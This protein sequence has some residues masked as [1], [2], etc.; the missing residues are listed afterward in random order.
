VARPLRRLLEEA[1]CPICLEYFSDPVSMDYGHNFC[2]GCITEYH[3]KLEIE[4]AGVF[5]PQCRSKVK[6]EKS[7]A[8]RQL[9]RMVENIQQLGIK[10]EDLKKQT[11]CREHEDKLKLFCEDDGEVICLLCDKTQEHGSHTLVPIEDAAQE[12][13]ERVKCQRQRISSEFEKLQLLLNEKK[14][15]FIQ[16]L[17]EEERETLK[18]LNENVTKLSQQSS[19]LQQLITEIEEKCQQP[20]AELLQGKLSQSLRK[21]SSSWGEPVTITNK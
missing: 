2:R 7:Q 18:K 15:H 3:E 10:P 21:L 20:A 8:N 17:A 1:F 11:V 4:E 5:C 14:E 16:G 6:K 9:A 19:S 13:K 12:Y